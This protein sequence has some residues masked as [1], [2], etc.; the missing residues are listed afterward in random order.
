MQVPSFGP[1]QKQT[2]KGDQGLLHNASKNNISS[3]VISDPKDAVFVE[4][5]N[6]NRDGELTGSVGSNVTLTCAAHG[7]CNFTLLH[8]RYLA[9]A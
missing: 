1:A 8:R 7:K 5:H 3:C 6:L 2:Q 4:V 9:Q